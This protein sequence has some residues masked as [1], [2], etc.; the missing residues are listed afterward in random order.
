MNATMK[1]AA[2]AARYLRRFIGASQLSAM[3]D[4]CRGEERQ[5]F[6]DRFVALAQ[7]RT[8]QAA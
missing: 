2:E 1:E 5:W 7:V 6:K 3:G 8:K 4:T